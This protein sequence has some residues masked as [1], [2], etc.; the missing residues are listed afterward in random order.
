MVLCTGM[1]SGCDLGQMFAVQPRE[2]VYFTPNDTFYVV[3]YMDSPYNLSRDIDVEQWRLSIT[4]EVAH[5]RSMG[6]RDIL[7]RISFDQAVTLI[8]IDTL[9][10]G[11]S[12]GNAMWQEEE[13]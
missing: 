6:W 2:T 12:V 7:N 4:G 13:F 3:N 1:T 9:P 11:V 10:G 5:R 8:C